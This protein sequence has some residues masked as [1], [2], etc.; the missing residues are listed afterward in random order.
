MLFLLLPLESHSVRTHTLMFFHKY[1]CDARFC[2]LFFYVFCIQMTKEK[3]KINLGEKVKNKN[4]TFE[5]HHFIKKKNEIILIYVC[6]YHFR[7][8]THFVV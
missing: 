6:I 7:D 1:L 3:I 8:I 4:K 2:L 5:S